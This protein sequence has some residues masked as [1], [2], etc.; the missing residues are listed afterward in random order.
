MTHAGI[1]HHLGGVS[2]AS[3][4][5][6]APRLRHT[7]TSAVDYQPPY[8][9]PPY[10][11]QHVEFPHH[12]HSVNP[13]PYGHLSQYQTHQTYGHLGDQR[14]MINQTDI[15]SISR[16]F[17]TAGDYNRDF[18]RNVLIP[19]HHRTHELHDPN[20]LLGLQG[21]GTPIPGLDDGTQVCYVRFIWIFYYCILKK[22]VHV[23]IL[24]QVILKILL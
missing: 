11:P 10:Q 13:D 22:F 3:S 5:S 16:G 23:N 1:E 9:P 19:S 2:A 12:P 7:P 8:F 21:G 6:N 18:G 20:S 24:F 15:N 14:H 4:F 17:P